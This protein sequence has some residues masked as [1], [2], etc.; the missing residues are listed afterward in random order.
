MSQLDYMKASDEAEANGVRVTAVY[1]SH[2]GAGAYLSTMDL[3]YAESELFPFPDASHIV[4]AVS[5]DRKVDSVAFFRQE[6]ESRSFSGRT[7]VSSE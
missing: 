5:A 1:H 6:T 4:V 2:V 3:E 7:V